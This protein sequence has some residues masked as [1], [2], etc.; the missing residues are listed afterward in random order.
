M[1]CAQGRSDNESRIPHPAG[2]G[3]GVTHRGSL[4]HSSDHTFSSIWISER[5]RFSE[6]G[7]EGWRRWEGTQGAG[8]W[9]VQV[10]DTG[11]DLGFCGT[12]SPQQRSPRQ[13]ESKASDRFP[14]P[15]P[16]QTG[17]ATPLAGDGD[18]VAGGGGG[19]GLFPKKP[20]WQL[21]GFM[22]DLCPFDARRTW[23]SR[24]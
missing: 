4:V 10:P 3:Q 1:V 5:L 21:C 9:G 20:R 14:A 11:Q 24:L 17:K 22:L 7:A 23:R 16:R 6:R 15:S 19:R 13:I 18:V 12:P 2:G 8:E